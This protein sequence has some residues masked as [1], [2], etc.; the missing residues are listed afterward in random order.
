MFHGYST[1]R[2]QMTE[3]LPIAAIFLLAGAI[4]GW[5]LRDLRNKDSSILLEAQLSSLQEQNAMHEHEMEAL[6]HTH[7]ATI[8]ALN[9]EARALAVE[10]ERASRVPELEAKLARSYEML[11]QSR[12]QLAELGTRLAEERKAASEK[13]DLL[14]N[15]QQQLSDTF[16]A[17]TSKALE[18]NN[19]SLITLVRATLENFQEG[20]KKDL[21]KRQKAM[22]EL[23]EPVKKIAGGSGRQTQ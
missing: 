17:L 5:I 6:Q 22:E 11:S 20:A 7:A 10:Q 18:S 14:N 16:S 15:T 9:A 1:E 4:V 13:L 12:V 2:E 3:I 23:A 21:E 8:D 19:Q